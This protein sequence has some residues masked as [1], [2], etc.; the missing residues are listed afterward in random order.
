MWIVFAL[1]ACAQFALIGGYLAARRKAGPPHADPKRWPRLGD[2]VPYTGPVAAVIGTLGGWLI[3]RGDR[4]LVVLGLA[5]V[6]LPLLSG[7]AGALLATGRRH[8]DAT[9]T[10]PAN[11]PEATSPPGAF[12][13]VFALIALLGGLVAGLTPLE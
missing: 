3:T 5:G 11:G 6:V 10:S 1:V 13:K 9:G 8:K 12:T 2:E 4:D 7:Q